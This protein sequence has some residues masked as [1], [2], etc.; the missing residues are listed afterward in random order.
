MTTRWA[1]YFAPVRG[2]AHGVCDRSTDSMPHGTATRADWA[3]LVPFGSES[4]TPEPRHLAPDLL[5][6]KDC[7]SNSGNTDTARVARAR[8]PTKSRAN[9]GALRARAFRALHWFGQTWQ[10]NERTC[11]KDTSLRRS[12]SMSGWSDLWPKAGCR[13]SGPQAKSS[14]SPPRQVA[15]R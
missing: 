11:R 2:D 1:P 14:V 3:V 12:F 8:T 4:R 13:T 7:A 6:P 9:S 15:R 5:H 10:G